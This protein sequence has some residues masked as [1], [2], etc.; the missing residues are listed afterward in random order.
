ME[1]IISPAAAEFDDRLGALQ[2]AGQFLEDQIGAGPIAQRMRQIIGTAHDN[3]PLVGPP[4][5]AQF[6]V[7]DLVDDAGEIGFAGGEFPLDPV[8]D[9][10]PFLAAIF[11]LDPGRVAANSMLCHSSPSSH[12]GRPPCHRLG[13][14]LASLLL[15]GVTKVASQQ[16]RFD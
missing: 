7:F 10:G 11:T 8:Q 2:Q 16:R 6:P 14:S 9:G 13:R 3:H 12:A 5:P 4:A 15:L 1:Q